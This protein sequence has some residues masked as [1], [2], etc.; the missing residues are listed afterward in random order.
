[1]S[2]LRLPVRLCTPTCI[3]PVNCPAILIG[4]L[5]LKN[6]N[7]QCENHE[8]GKLSPRELQG[9]YMA[10]LSRIAGCAPKCEDAKRHTPIFQ[11]GPAIGEQ[12]AIRDAANA[13]TALWK[14]REPIKRAPSIKVQ[15]KAGEP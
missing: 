7:R 13:L 10:A 5:G 8:G 11:R 1:M 15:S 3:P 2:S 4:S 9:T 6:S 12:Q 14:I